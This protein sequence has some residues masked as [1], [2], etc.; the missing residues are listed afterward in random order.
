VWLLIIKILTNKDMGTKLNS[1]RFSPVSISGR[2]NKVGN[3]F[4]FFLLRYAFARWFVRD[5]TSC[6]KIA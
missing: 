2:E 6:Q 1:C 4:S 5:A 3:N